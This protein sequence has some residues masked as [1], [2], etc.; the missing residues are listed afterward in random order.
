MTHNCECC[1]YVTN[2]KFNYEKHLLSERHCLIEKSLL[3][4]QKTTLKQPTTTLRQPYDNL[5]TTLRHQ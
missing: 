1:K 3:I 2:K 4:Q 5:T